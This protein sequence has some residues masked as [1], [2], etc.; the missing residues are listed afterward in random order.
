[1][2]HQL[3]IELDHAGTPIGQVKP[4]LRNLLAGK[5][6]RSLFSTCNEASHSDRTRRVT[7]MSLCRNEF[8]VDD[9]V[10]TLQAFIKDDMD[11][12]EAD[13]PQSRL[14]HHPWEKL[15]LRALAKSRRVPVPHFM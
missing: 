11:D 6:I 13:A 14:G 12:N 15:G 5:Q 9:F 7:K 3:P 10:S 8:N 2:S 4:F 1:M